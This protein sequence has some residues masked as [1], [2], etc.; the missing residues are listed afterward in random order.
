MACIR[1]LENGRE[2]TFEL[3]DATIRIGRSPEN[4]IVL[5]DTQSSR[6]HCEIERVAGGYK[7]VDLESKNGTKVNGRFVNQHFL[8]HLD[9][10]E[11]GNA[12]LL[13]EDSKA[14]GVSRIVG[15][16]APVEAVAALPPVWPSP[17]ASPVVRTSRSPLRGPR[18]PATASSILFFTIVVALILGIVMLL[19]RE[20]PE[21]TRTR[22]AFERAQELAERGRNKYLKQ[23]IPLYEIPEFAEAKAEY[24]KVSPNFADYYSHAKDALAELKG[25]LE[26]AEL[27]KKSREENEAFYAIARYADN[28]PDDVQGILER[29]EKFRTRYP[30][31]VLLSQIETI[32]ARAKEKRDMVAKEDF[33]MTREICKNFA[34]SKHYGRAVTILQDFIVKR[35]TA[36]QKKEAESLL[37]EILS[38]AE[39]FFELKNEEAQRLIKDKKYKEANDV[40]EM[41]LKCLGE[42]KVPDFDVLCLRAKKEM[43]RLQELMKQ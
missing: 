40:Y 30:Q 19:T 38:D 21:L 41:L 26:R 31:S 32:A 25:I 6:N 15:P 3:G 36:E 28:N 7:L 5:E 1:L 17:H 24:E 14:V 39:S 16:G 11:I 43:E 27:E 33:A 12:V 18:V 10:I 37:Q 29:C 9:R 22:R 2:R 35:G 42:E 20:D 34:N 13:F 23:N 8:V 4:N